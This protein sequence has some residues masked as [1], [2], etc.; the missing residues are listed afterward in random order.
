MYRLEPRV[1]VCL[2]RQLTG[3]VTD[4]SGKTH[5]V[6]KGHWDEAIRLAKVLDGEEKTATL[7]EFELAWTNVPPK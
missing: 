4:E 5:Y 2:P 1:C 7:S 3:S 6:L